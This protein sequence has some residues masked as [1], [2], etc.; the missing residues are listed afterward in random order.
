MLYERMDWRYI[1]HVNPTIYAQH[2]YDEEY[3]HGL[4]ERSCK[5]VRNVAS[6]RMVKGMTGEQKIGVLKSLG[7]VGSRETLERVTH[8]KDY[9]L[10][11]RFYS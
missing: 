8:A 1:K 4:I 11:S 9:D 5:I 2:M 10:M 3:V 6:V 7:L